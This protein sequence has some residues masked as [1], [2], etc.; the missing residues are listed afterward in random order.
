MVWYRD[1]LLYKATWNPSS[2][3]FSDE[4]HTLRKM[5]SRSSYEG[6]G[7][8]LVALDKA[9]IRLNANVNF[10]LTMELMLLT[11]KEN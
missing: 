7:S 5:A 8:I 4:I 1:V 6:I 10:E 2:I 3:L 11:M 9:K